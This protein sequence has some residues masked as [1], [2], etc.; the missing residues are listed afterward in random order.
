MYCNVPEVTNIIILHVKKKDVSS[1]G[2][3][4]NCD[5]DFSLRTMQHWERTEYGALYLFPSYHYYV[6]R[7]N[8]L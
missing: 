3:S 7:D 1:F 8:K 6:L 4:L 2:N 5:I